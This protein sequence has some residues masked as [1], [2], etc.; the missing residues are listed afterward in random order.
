M[1]SNLQ[2][3]PPLAPTVPVGADEG[4]IARQSG[5]AGE[6]VTNSVLA[7]PFLPSPLGGEGRVRGCGEDGTLTIYIDSKRMFGIARKSLVLRVTR[8]DPVERA[9]AAMAALEVLRR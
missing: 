1:H 5:G 8:I 4:R 9:V 7:N 2:Y 3:I 6:V